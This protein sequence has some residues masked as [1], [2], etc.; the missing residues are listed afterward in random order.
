MSDDTLVRV[1]DTAA[2]ANAPGAADALDEFGEKLAAFRVLTKSDGAAADALLDQIGGRGRVES[3]IVLQLG[4][5]KP[6]WKP[7]RFEDGHMLAMRSLEVL[8]RNGGRGA[9]LPRLGPLKPAASWLVQLLTR[10][11]VRSYVSKV[12]DALRHLYGRRE[13]SSPWGSPEMH[14]LRRARIH[15]E[16]LAPG[17]KRKGLGLPTFLVGGAAI[18]SVVSLLRGVSEAAKSQKPV[19]VAVAIA[20]FLFFL[21]ASWCLLIASATARRRIRLTTHAPLQ[22]LWDIIGAAGDPPRDDSRNF[23]LYGLLLTAVGW[24]VLPVAL[25]VLLVT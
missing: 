19:L 4:A 2:D 13:A 20:V 12:I 3:D 25:L 22:A 9:K 10:L 11:I 15:A 7:A 5:R 23:A 16:R 18:S 14:S 17:Y 8:D 21:G 6:L 24:L 1:A